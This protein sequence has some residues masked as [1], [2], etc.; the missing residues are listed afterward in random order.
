MGAAAGSRTDQCLTSRP[1]ELGRLRDSPTVI[2]RRA[3]QDPT[4]GMT[5]QRS[6]APGPDIPRECHRRQK[7]MGCSVMSNDQPKGVPAPLRSFEP[8]VELLQ[9]APEE[10]VR[11]GLNSTVR[12][13]E[14]PVAGDTDDMAEQ[15][16]PV[17]PAEEVP[18]T[19][20]AERWREHIETSRQRGA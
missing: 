13:N 4:P 6:I 10:D 16:P 17:V 14:G 15:L 3:F 7:T 18:R 19:T 11:S 12:E 9:E 1:V 8:A 5:I 2:T 20:L